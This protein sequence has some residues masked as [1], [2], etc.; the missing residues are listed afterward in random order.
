MILNGFGIIMNNYLL[1]QN[2]TDLSINISNFITGSY[3]V[4]LIVD[5][6]AIDA[7]TLIVQ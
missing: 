1:N 3:N 6:Q 4:I 5:G 7:K 2:S